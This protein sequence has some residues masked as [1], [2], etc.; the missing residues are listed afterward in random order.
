MSYSTQKLVHHP[1]ALAAMRARRPQ[2]PTLVHFMP[3]LACNQRCTFCSYGHRA[4]EDGPEQFGWKNMA[5]MSDAFM[6]LEK[7]RECVRDWTDMGVKAVEL[8]G[9]GEPL[10]YPFVD[11][12]FAQMA[13]SG[14]ELAMVTNGTALTAARAVRFGETRWKW[15][16]VSIDAGN[17]DS[18][19]ATR[20]VPQSHWRRAWEA[21]GRLAA[22][23]TNPEQRVGVGY[24][25]DTQNFDGIYEACDLAWQHGADN[26]R[27]ALAFT[28]MN[29]A[30][31][32]AGA[33]DEAA[34]QADAAARDFAGKLQVN[35]LV[36]ERKAN[37]DADVQDYE[38]CA[39]KEVICVVGGD[40]QAYTCCSLA[41]NELGLIGSIKAQSFRSMWEKETPDFF[42]THDA[43]RVC[44]IPCLYEKRNKRALELIAMTPAQVAREAE[45]D[46]GTHRNF[47]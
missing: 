19:T 9:G 13:L 45:A 32:P 6:P 34:R 4:V 42:A 33:V 39:V 2:A 44:R 31:F 5:L 14:L 27:V 35:G 22:L 1:E 47:I 12:F 16:R 18:Y 8:T 21:V 29:L 15:A 37:M 30:R 40:Q 17:V 38:F 20:R 23:K 41:F 24:V 43:R 25:V 26:V 46:P 7:M 36:R 10:I 28:P 11:D 3:A